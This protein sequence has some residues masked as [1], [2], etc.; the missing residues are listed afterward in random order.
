[1][2]DN[3]SSNNSEIK[4][5][6]R[7]KCNKLPT[8][9]IQKQQQQQQQNDEQETVNDCLVNNKNL[10]DLKKSIFRFSMTSI[11][12]YEIEQQLKRQQQNGQE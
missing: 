3:N 11:S 10:I 6:R 7:I 5:T 4:I 12:T 2:Q 9:E 8:L 1:M